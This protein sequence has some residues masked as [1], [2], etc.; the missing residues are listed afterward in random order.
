MDVTIDR[1][2]LSRELAV[3]ERVVARKV[4]MPIL[5]TVLMH[6]EQGILKMEATDIDL[7]IK[8]SA[9]ADVAL[10]GKAAVP[11]RKFYELVRSLSGDK[12]RFS[13]DGQAL[14]VNSAGYK[15]RLQTQ[16]V[17]DFPYIASPDKADHSFV[18]PGQTLAGL[19]SRTRPFTTESDKRFFMAGALLEFGADYVR[20]VSTDAHRLAK[21]DTAFEGGPVEPFSAIVPRKA[22]DALATMLE[23]SD[24]DVVFAASGNHLFFGLDDRL[25]IS[26]K[27]DGQFPDYRRVMPTS[28]ATTATVVRTALGQAMKRASLVADQNSRRVDLTVGP[29]GIAITTTSV[30]VGEAVEELA[31]EH[32]GAEVAFAVCGPYI[33]AFVEA[34]KTEKVQVRLNSSRQQVG[35][36]GVG[37][38]V[39][40]EYVVAPVHQ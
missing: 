12:L 28:Y 39:R 16:S 18:V 3:V 11:A 4:V 19:V 29:N 13:M 7:S 37:G 26:R 20:M 32:E 5:S 31:S 9:E 24:G 21:A 23:E 8:T 2:A 1:A 27:V 25:L 17:D 10:K 38:D 33:E 6:A 35:L 30:D 36:F 14:V 22:L 40:Y 34:V 15:A